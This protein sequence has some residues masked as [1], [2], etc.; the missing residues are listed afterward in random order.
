MTEITVSTNWPLPACSNAP[1][2]SAP[3]WTCGMLGS[4]TKAAPAATVASAVTAPLLPL[5]DLQGAG[6]PAT[7]SAELTLP[8]R[9]LRPLPFFAG[10]RCH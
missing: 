1:A 7:T 3:A 2:P 4:K 8:V 10:C 6:L 9:M 5:A